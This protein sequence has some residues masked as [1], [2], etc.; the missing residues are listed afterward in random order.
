VFWLLAAALLL[1][2]TL[3][4]GFMPAT[5]EGFGLVLCTPQGLLGADA[6]AEPSGEGDSG[7]AMECPFALL[8]VHPMAGGAG[9]IE[10]FP[11]AAHP[12]L[13]RAWMAVPLRAY[14]GAASARGPP[15]SL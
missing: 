2:A 6:T 15:A 3:P 1:R 7:Q 5:G 14:A 10:S 8:L 13:H 4:S 9:A 11:P 12:F